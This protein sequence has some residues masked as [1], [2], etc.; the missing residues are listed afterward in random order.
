MRF[1]VALAVAVLASTPVHADEKGFDP[2]VVYNVPLGTAPISGPVDAPITIVVWSDHACGFCFRVQSTLTALTELY[3]RQLRWVHRTLPLDDGRTISAEASMAAGAQGALRPMS[4]RLY[5]L[6][7][8]VDRAGVELIARELGLDMRRFRA[9]LDNRTFYPQVRADM[10]DANK[11]GVRGTPTFFINGRPVHGAQQLKVF[12][13]VIE[14]E[15]ARMVRT[16]GTYEQLVAHGRPTADE[17]EGTEHPEFDFIDTS[18]Y[19]VGLGLPGHQLGPESALVTIIVWSDF[20]CPFC[21]RSAPV[22]TALR[23]KYGNDVR[24]VFRHLA[25]TMHRRAALASEAAVA[26]A[27]QGKFWAFHDRLFA[28]SGALERTDLEAA[29]QEIGLD[30]T[31][32]K[33]ALD[34][35]RYYAAVLAEGAS[36]QALGVS[37]TPTMFVNGQPVVGSRDIAAMETIVTAHLER[38]RAAVNAGIAPTDLFAIMMSDAEGVER[39]DP[40]GVP[41]VAA[42]AIAPHA[43]ERARSVEAAC[44]RRDAVRA[45]SLA[46]GLLA[47]H[48]PGVRM[49]CAAAGIDL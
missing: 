6:V 2:E 15:L 13:D 10:D 20:Q 40:S 28:Q 24:I 34:D 36:G 32:F 48:A 19:R 38:A 37:G 35:R 9:D 22:L 26:A 27:V 25:M 12:V 5:S 39:A 45:R 46:P 14:H 4:D 7:G 49:I 1:V 18:H 47:A 11:L 30:M 31:T 8:R 33:A 17:P 3:P 21:A 16:P 42:A 23:T 41:D 29:A 44:R 43:F